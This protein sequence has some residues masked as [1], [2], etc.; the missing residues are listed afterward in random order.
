MIIPIF[1]FNK[2]EFP[3]YE[4]NL[5]KKVDIIVK[6]MLYLMYSKYERRDQLMLSRNTKATYQRTKK[7][8]VVVQRRIIL[9]LLT[10]LTITVLVVTAK[11]SIDISRKKQA[12]DIVISAKNEANKILIEAKS[13]ASIVV[14][15][16]T[17]KANQKA[18]TITK[19][20]ETKAETITKTA[21]TKAETITKTA[22]AKAN[23]I[24]D[25]AIDTQIDEIETL[26]A[27]TEAEASN[28]SVKGKAAVAATIKNRIGSD[29]FKAD[30]IKEVVYSPGQFDPVSSGKINNVVATASTIEGVKLCLQGKDYSNGALY[31]Y[32]PSIS[33]GSNASWFN[34]LK[35]TAVI[36]DHVFKR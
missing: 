12:Q 15:T 14:S 7:E 6:T 19:T 13:D 18:E 21:E 16:T 34:S 25:K 31:F 2:K 28:Q 24:V 36:G 8:T 4:F 26:L 3:N 35:T 29:Q 9:V 27:I 33:R 20:A 17:M 32:N 10:L 22:E 5:L 30:S 1:E 23:K 11:I